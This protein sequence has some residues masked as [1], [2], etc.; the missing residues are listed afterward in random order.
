MKI[1]IKSIAVEKY[2]GKY[3]LIATL[4]N[5]TPCTIA[6]S[7]NTTDALIGLQILCDQLKKDLRIW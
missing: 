3:L 1:N 5:N 4:E 6:E 2:G 7:T